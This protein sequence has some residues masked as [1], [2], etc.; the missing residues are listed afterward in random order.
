MLSRLEHPMD[1][2]E[3]LARV[4]RYIDALG[5]KR[6]RAIVFGSVARGDYTAESDTDLLIV[7]DDLPPD[8]RQRLEHLFRARDLAPEIEPIGW[9]EAE[10]AR[11]EAR[12]DPFLA[13]LDLEG[14]SVSDLLPEHDTATAERTE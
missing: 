14:R 4:S 10:W 1:R 8:P 9:T 12:A 7:S 3:R 5:L 6:Y 11:R 13:I 2:A